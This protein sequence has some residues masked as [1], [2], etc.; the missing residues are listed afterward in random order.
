MRD[1]LQKYSYIE[2]PLFLIKVER[3]HTE[4]NFRFVEVNQS[5]LDMVGLKEEQ[6]IGNY[7]DDFIPNKEANFLKGKYLEAFHL[8]EVLI[9][10]TDVMLPTGHVVVD[11][12]LLPIKD[13]EDNVSYI[14]GTAH[15]ITKRKEMEVKVI[16]AELM[17]RNLV[18]KANVGVYIIQKGYFVYFNQKMLDIFG[19][20]EEELQN[21]KALDIVSEEDFEYV[22]GNISKRLNTELSDMTYE[23]KGK[24]KDGKIVQVEV[25]GSKTLYKGK[26]AIIGTLIDLTTKKEVEGELRK[27]EDRYRK[28]VE[29]SPEPIIV[30]KNHK[31]VYV[32]PA[33]VKIIGANSQSD[34][35]GKD[36]VELFHEEDQAFIKE[37][38]KRIVNGTDFTD[39]TEVRM[40]GVDGSIKYVEAFGSPIF[41]EGQSARL[42]LIRDITKRKK[43]EEELREAQKQL[44]NIFNSLDIAI[45][46]FDVEQRKLT[47]M[48]T[49]IEKIFGFPRNKF[50]EDSHY[51]KELV[52]PDDLR[53]LRERK[54]YL[55]AGRTLNFEYRITTANGTKKWIEEQTI[56]ILDENGKVYQFNGVISDITD[57]KKYEEQVSYHSSYD[58]LTG[59]PNRILL[60]DRLE[61]AI[62]QSNRDQEELA[63]L[64]LNLNR[65]RFINDT[66]GQDLGDL[67][68]KEVAKRIEGCLRP[69]DTVS[70]YNG[71]EFVFIFPNTN[72]NEVVGIAEKLLGCIKNSFVFGEH[73]FLITASIGISLY[74]F[75][76][77][78]PKSLIKNADVAMYRAKKQGVNSYAFFTLEMNHTNKERFE[79]EKDLRKA[80]EFNQFVLYYQP[81]IDVK[82]S[83][84]VGLEA[85]VRWEHPN[86]GLIPPGKFISL[87]E[88]TEL[89]VPLGEWVLEEACTQNKAW[90][91]AGLPPMRMAVN[92]SAK[93]FRQSDLTD[94][95]ANVLKKTGMPAEYLELEITEGTAMKGDD[96]LEVLKELQELGIKFSIDD[97]GTGY[98]SLSYLKKF[99]I[100][101]LKIDKSFILD[102][103]EDS[104]DAS[105]VSTIILMA[106]HLNLSVIAEGVETKE[107]VEFLKNEGC[108]EMQGFYFSRP[109]SAEKIEEYLE[110]NIVMNK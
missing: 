101:T 81:Q 48:S 2:D 24:T 38:S 42:T 32:N 68:L 22:K 74:P 92:L 21:I 23:F 87:A 15:D 79:L 19:Y 75:D 57:R 54:K 65:F 41:F 103:K 6:V 27:S 3:D 46:S 8:K 20:T 80:L 56:P 83:E 100:N 29:L 110:N 28:L 59:L 39:I 86:L 105:I 94:T 33:G 88:E 108:D 37:R 18:E 78:D 99:P 95:V 50:L 30:H 11:S 71:D 45:W 102:L 89:I 40:V 9:Y 51:W 14:I 85:L 12:K 4:I 47:T 25:H 90:I 77:N 72:R 67:V 70:R 17:Y 69:G 52:H 63:V 76:G 31:L 64:F 49:G 107:H 13:E 61:L 5:Y 43:V 98:S 58:L 60:L 10:E 36:I 1:Y 91:D 97:F 109:V 73:D 26:Q 96:T 62:S 93:Q 53:N 7:I 44:D 84:I 106:H 82:T 55:L 66:L 34:L 35:I 16:E 104:D